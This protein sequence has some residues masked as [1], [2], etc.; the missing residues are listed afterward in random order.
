M[1]MD[2]KSNEN[3]NNNKISV[4]ILCC[5]EKPD[6]LATFKS[7]A[8]CEDKISECIIAD[9]AGGLRA[10]EIEQQAANIRY[11][12][13]AENVYQNVAQLKN[14]AVKLAAYDRILLVNAGDDICLEERNCLWDFKGENIF[15][16]LMLEGRGI[17][18]HIIVS[19]RALDVIGGWNTNLDCG[20]DYELALRA[21][22]Y[23]VE[24]SCTDDLWLTDCEV[25]LREENP[26][27]PIFREDYFTYSYV[28]AKY[29]KK[30]K[31]WGLFDEVFLN[32]YN[33]AVKFGIKD[34]FVTCQENFMRRDEAFNKLDEATRP[35]LI[36]KEKS[37]C[38]GVLYRFAEMF[39]E[40]LRECGQNVYTYTIKKGG[41]ELM[42]EE[43]FV[44]VITAR[45]YK[46]AI[47]FQAGIFGWQIS[48]GEL[49]GNIMR[50]PKFMYEF[51]HPLYISYHFMLPISNY[52]VLSQDE[53]YAKYLQEYFPHVKAAWH[54]P[55]AGEQVENPASK[56]YGM[57]FVAA[58]NNYRDCLPAIRDMS[59]DERK[60]A[61][62]MLK[63]L[64]NNSDMTAEAALK[65]ALYITDCVN[66]DDKRSFMVL[67]HQMR[68]VV[69]TVT[70]YYREKVVK[71]LVE[72]G[73]ELH[74]FSDTWKKC[75]FADNDKLIIHHDVP[76]EEG[77]KIIAESR[78]TLNVMSW[79]KGGMTERVANAMLNKAVCVTDKTTYIERHFL[80][81]EDIV[82]FDLKDIESLPAR[83]KGLFSV[84]GHEKI[85]AITEAAYKKV[86]ASHTWANR[87]KAFMEIL[88]KIN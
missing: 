27:I 79:H 15:K 78:V 63:I 73:I 88:S 74:V 17:L 33:E 54:M 84:G 69:H 37:V 10:E 11:F 75:P 67:L 83:I 55:L 7:L 72:A 71:N 61:L 19:R 49:V 81:G 56:R 24:C 22:D 86:L 46:T 57:T 51:D 42:S 65:E 41:E 60:I 39:A 45:T 85:E 80:D 36:F 59:G 30:L 38:N 18:Q 2:N 14:D 6:I 34:Y 12:S 13:L 48:S 87:A 62:E 20:E 25:V 50:C 44:N 77:L 28:I 82:M 21:C 31:A 29:M 5:D 35:I 1:L 26:D 4:I 66:C 3:L 32:R 58:Y 16:K 53:T 70:F 9:A 47:D 64:K 40:A 8:R 52:Y 23:S 76:Y 43:Q 68:E